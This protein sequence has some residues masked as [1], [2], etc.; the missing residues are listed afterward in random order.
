MFAKVDHWFVLVA[1][2]LVVVEAADNHRKH[3]DSLR[4]KLADSRPELADTQTDA[5]SHL[6]SQ[7]AVEPADIAAVVEVVASDCLRIV[8]LAGLVDRTDRLSVVN[9]VE[10]LAE[11]MLQQLLLVNASCRK[12]LKQV[13]EAVVNFVIANSV[14]ATAAALGSAVLMAADLKSHVN[15]TLVNVRLSDD[16]RQQL[17]LSVL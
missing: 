5:G 17:T 11:A 6:D 12:R 10:S 4:L 9:S 14:T 15:S 16:D 1:V 2:V 7:L 3:L 8:H 13:V